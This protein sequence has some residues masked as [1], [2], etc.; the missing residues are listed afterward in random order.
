MFQNTLGILGAIIA[1]GFM[2]TIHEFGHFLAARY[3]GVRVDVFSFG[4]GTRLFGVKRGNTDYRVSIL[5]LGGYVRM[6]GDNASEE[7]TGAPDE[8]MSKPRW[9]RVVILLAGP[10]M[11][12]ITSIVIFAFLFGG[13]TSQPAFYDKPVVVAGVS[14]G[15]AAERAGI[16]A[17]DQLVNINGAQNPTW[18]RAQLEAGFTIPGNPIPITID[19]SGQLVSTSVVSSM[20][21]LDMFGYPAE[22]DGLVTVETVSPGSP[23]DRAGLKPADKIVSYNGIPIQSWYQFTQLVKQRE[24]LPG[25]LVISRG[26]HPMQLLVHPMKMD[27]GDGPV[28]WAVGFTHHLDTERADKG[29]LDSIGFSAWFNARLSRQMVSL[30][31]QLFVG[32][33]SLK[34]V[35]GPLGIVTASGRAARDGFKNLMF[36]VGLISLNLG[37]LNLLPIPILDGGH[38]VMLAVESSLRHDLSLK[39]KERFLQVGF[40]FILVVF[41]IV[42]Y[43]DV[44]RLFQHS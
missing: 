22:P 44:L 43:N 33:A 3:F 42:M 16:Q 7:R 11:N 8:F 32:R 37:V 34:Q 39:A 2:V 9:N 5:P 36:M 6:A 21:G 31:G 23:A 14:K 12:V 41:A 20:D 18:E 1:L 25:Q 24:G 38:I 10:A 15:S 35:Q 4:F 19:R 40:V 29:I 28:R 17:G 26:G 13:V 27:L 30:V